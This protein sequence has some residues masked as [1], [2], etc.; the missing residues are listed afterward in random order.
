VDE[1]IEL[2]LGLPAG[3]PDADGQYPADTVYGLVAAQLE[4]FDRALDARDA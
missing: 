2:F 1:A 4:K 3:V